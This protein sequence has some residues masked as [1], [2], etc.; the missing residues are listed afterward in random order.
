MRPDKQPVN[1]KKEADDINYSAAFLFDYTRYAAMIRQNRQ[2]INCMNIA[3]L[4][5]LETYT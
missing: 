2:M 3:A 4:S 5:D 1:Q